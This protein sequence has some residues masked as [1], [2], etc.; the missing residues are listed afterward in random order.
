MALL[1]RRKAAGDAPAT[2]WRG[3]ALAADGISAPFFLGIAGAVF[4]WGYDGLAFVLGLGAGFLLLQLLVAPM[5]PLAGASSIPDYFA[6]RY[7]KTARV[8][9][10]FTV[11]L[12]MALL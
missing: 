8:A 9:A 1:S 11:V 12:S 3:L 7:G 6:K 5:L 2:A 10:G 4:T